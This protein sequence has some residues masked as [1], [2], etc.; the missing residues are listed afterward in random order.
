MPLRRRQ[1]F[2]AGGR[3]ES[4]LP[5]TGDSQK[6][7]APAAEEL[8]TTHGAG[9]VV[10]P[11]VTVLSDPPIAVVASWIWLGLPE[12]PVDLLPLTNPVH[13]FI[14]Q[15]Q[16]GL[17]PATWSRQ[18]LSLAQGTARHLPLLGSVLRRSAT[19][20]RTF[21]HSRACNPDRRSSSHR[22]LGKVQQ[23]FV[24]FVPVTLRPPTFGTGGDFQQLSAFQ[25]SP[26]HLSCGFSCLI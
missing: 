11:E 7:G 26:Y 4:P 19:R 5:P 21:G 1:G 6:G 25:F 16:E 23:V 8:V 14:G 15:R 13:L 18:H 10:A 24:D 12:F 22:R 17:P 3:S 20:A 9:L 2:R